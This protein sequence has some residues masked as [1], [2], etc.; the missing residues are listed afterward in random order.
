[1]RQGP[2]PSPRRPESGSPRTR[3]PRCASSSGPTRP[4]ARPGRRPCPGAPLWQ[5]VGELSRPLTHA[6][7]STVQARIIPSIATGRGRTSLPP[8]GAGGTAA[9]AP[10]TGVH[11]DKG[12]RTRSSG[13]DLRERLARADTAA[14]LVLGEGVAEGAG[15]LGGC[16]G[17]ASSRA[18][19]KCGRR[20]TTTMPIPR[21]RSGASGRTKAGSATR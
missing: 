12:A 3:R 8:A 16:S 6:G 20:G 2:S 18:G 7:S 15:A 1:M 19:P 5:A 4:W 14:E 13:K 21:L 17:P 9:D 11:R 10:L